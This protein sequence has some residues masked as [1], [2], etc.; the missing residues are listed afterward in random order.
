MKTTLLSFAF[1]AGLLGCPASAQDA[2]KAA[3]ADL[4]A[5]PQV[6]FERSQG[7]VTLRQYQLGCLSQLTYLI[8]SEGEALVVDPGRD[9]EHYLRDASALDAKIRYVALTHTNADFVAGHTE[10]AV[11]QGAQILISEASGSAFPHRG[12]RDGERLSLGKATIEFLA[13][14]GHTLDS[15]CFL[16]R[17]PGAEADPLYL[18]SGDT[19]FIGSIGRPD[20][21][22][23][24]IT[25]STLASRAFDSMQR[26]KALDPGTIVLPAHGAGSLCGAHLSPDTTSTIARELES[27]PFLQIKSRAAFVARDISGLPPAPRYFAYNVAQN[28]AGPPVVDWTAALPTALDAAG[29]A[30]LIAADSW[31]IDLRD[32]REY[33]AEHLSGSINVAVRGRLDTWTGIVIPFEARMILVGS[34]DEAREAQFRF[35]RI[36]LDRVAGWVD[37]SGGK[38]RE[39]GAALR[40]SEL[41]APEKL[42]AQIAA[43]EEPILVDVRGTEEHAELA[44][45]AYANLELSEWQRFGEVLDKQLPLL[46]VCNSAYRSSMAV[47]LAERLGFEH[48]A[49]LDGGL[50]AWIAAGQK[51]YGSAEICAGP[52]CP[53]PDASPAGRASDS[54]FELPEAIE[55]AVLATALMD[56]P[57]NYALFDVRPAWQHREYHVPGAQNIAPEALAA[58]LRD[59]P[60]GRRVV[61]VDR[62][63]T[64]GFAVAAAVALELGESARP[65]RVLSGGTARFWREIEVRSSAQPLPQLAPTPAAPSKPTPAASPK[66]RSAGC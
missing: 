55:P 17:V 27:N 35:K 49:S 65:L 60:A 58:Q 61:I 31:L 16:V 19:L 7:G 64:Q 48:V 33:A 22:Q 8:A 47:G 54:R 34:A 5:T 30:A 14:P 1:L 32:A 38:L 44:I 11:R 18:L 41:V 40:S 66:K 24:T 26:L 36:G 42:A 9:V 57:Q 39:L 29:L 63:G 56:Q 37:S 20:L 10:L 51:V 21:A 53:A 2:E 52:I 50:D 45:G 59:L 46:F 62:D 13:T 15:M 25:P 12:M 6:S 3:H 43:G 28:R 23:G 4:A